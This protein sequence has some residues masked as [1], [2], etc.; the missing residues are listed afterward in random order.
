MLYIGETKRSVECRLIEHRRGENN[1]NTFS[2]FATNLMGNKHKF[3]NPLE[4]FE[5]LKIKNKY[6][7]RKWREEL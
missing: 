6:R 4:K 2:I 1:R 7:E 5:T 3:I